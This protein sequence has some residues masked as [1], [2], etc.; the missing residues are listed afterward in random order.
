MNLRQLDIDSFYDGPGEEITDK[1]IITALSASNQFDRITSY[2]NINSLIE[3][4]TG[5]DFLLKNNGKFRLIIGIHDIPK[6]LLIISDEEKIKVH[7][8]E[9]KKRIYQ[10][11][12]TLKDAF[13][14]NRIKTLALLIN[15]GFLDIKI[16]ALKS[17]GLFH[18]KRLIFT[19]HGDSIVAVGSQ[20][21]TQSG[22]NKNSEELSVD[23]SWENPL[24]T[25]KLIKN[26]EDKWNNKD[27][28]LFVYELTKDFA[29]ELL[30]ALKTKNNQNLLKENSNAPRKIIELIRNSPNFW[31]TN[32]SSAALYPHQERAVRDGLT[33]WPLRLILADE[34]GLGKTLEA[35][36]LISFA[37]RNLNISKI[38]IFTPANLRKQ[39]QSEL[40][41]LFNIESLIY[42]SR[43]Q[44]YID[45]SGEII[46]SHDKGANPLDF[47]PDISIVSWQLAR[48]MWFKN[49]YIQTTKNKIN[50][51][52][53][54]EAHAAR[55]QLKDNGQHSTTLVWDMLNSIQNTVD[56]MIL[57]TA[58]PM[59]IQV[60][61]YIGL[62]ELLGLPDWWRN[63]KN[64]KLLLE[65]VNST[66]SVNLKEIKI[67]VDSI[68][69][70]LENVKKKDLLA[71]ESTIL[72]NKFNLEGEL[73]PQSLYD[74]KGNHK[75]LKKIALEVSPIK[76]LTI[77]NTKKTLE[78]FKYTFPQR[79]FNI[80]NLQIGASGKRLIE[81]IS[82]YINEY[83]GTV[84][85][86]IYQKEAKGKSFIKAVYYQRLVSSFTS[87]KT[88]LIRRKEKLNLLL[89]SS[90]IN[91]SQTKNIQIDDDDNDF[92]DY[93]AGDYAT[94]TNAP[95]NH[96]LLDK[97]V[98]IE[99]QYIDGIIK[100]IDDL[101]IQKDPKLIETIKLLQDKIKTNSKV[102]LFSKYTDTLDSFIQYVTAAIPHLN[103]GKYTGSE[104]YISV[105][106]NIQSVDKFLLTNALNNGVVNVVFCSDAASE[107]LNL[108][109]ANTIINIDV[110]WNPAKLEQ[111]IGRIARLGQKSPSV[112]II[113]LWYPGTI[114]SQIYK[115]L[116]NRQDL[117][118]LAV[119]EFPDVIGDKIRQAIYENNSDLFFDLQSDINYYRDKTNIESLRKIWENENLGISIGQNFRFLL[120]DFIETYLNSHKIVHDKNNH[121]TSLIVN[122]EVI[123]YTPEPGNP[124]SLTIHHKIFDFLLNQKKEYPLKEDLYKLVINNFDSCVAI[125][126]N[127]DYHL[128][129]PQSTIKLLSSML[130]GT[131]FELSSQEIVT[132]LSSP[133]EIDRALQKTFPS[134]PNFSG[135]STKNTE[136]INPMLINNS[137]TICF[138]PINPATY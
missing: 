137:A 119:G 7:I 50:L 39:W 58:T 135:Y 118:N 36:T 100:Y 31:F 64:F 129:N 74:I 42:E 19:N 24:K 63:T 34:V 5:L 10:D 61:E 11:C 97:K 78:K 27:G 67:L 112:E 40:K 131:T 35:A 60:D 32:C 17:G 107:G 75:E 13:L 37:K 30:D 127:E 44:A 125:K 90:H 54:D 132:S 86:E 80:P 23:K 92:I 121:Q 51:I 136:E 122:N 46:I 120:S 66:E 110:P 105:S 47:C 126:R 76:N 26:F 45:S 29:N 70:S 4:S 106:K 87:A 94:I 99:I 89:S 73:S 43:L 38:I 115:Q 91:S 12:K 55:K 3:C 133:S 109:A 20:N 9:A 49:N 21:F 85:D 48:N 22:M 101:A 98:K 114:E 14:S 79:N 8:E 134:R 138:I 117:Y 71:N 130:C 18:N 123:S 77:R 41:K 52:M 104:S 69:S 103:F 65:A 68:R 28:N 56:H 116:I 15:S 83:Y 82:T 84:E 6:E 1:L 128:L 59:Q 72:L 16:A 33:N 111:R 95:F 108:Q 93:F 62:L 81:N 124:N 2:F 57:L 53:V 25:Q 88:T 102:L 96:E 113:N